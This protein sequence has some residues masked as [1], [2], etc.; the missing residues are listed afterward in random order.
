MARPK[1]TEFLTRE[2]IED[3][4]LRMSDTDAAKELGVGMVTFYNRRI[5]FGIPSF[6]QRTGLRK[7]KNGETY[8]FLEYNENYFQSIDTPAK[9][10][11]L[12]LLAADGNISPR[13]TA[14][15]IAL[16]E[17]DQS[18]L[19][20]FRRELGENAP[21][22]KDKIPYI[23]GKAGRTQKVL[24]LSRVKMVNDLI[25]L[26]ITPNKSHTLEMKINLKDEL[27][28]HFLRGVWDGDG[29]VTERRFKV[30]TGS[31][32][33]AKQLQKWMLD[34]SGVELPIKIDSIRIVSGEKHAPLYAIP[35]YLQ[36]ARVIQSIYGVDGP[37]MSRKRSN[38]LKYW[39]PRR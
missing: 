11:F 3:Y 39:D 31:L 32:N 18:I 20:E 7:R 21:R 24:C 8:S 28:G 34:V 26:G 27:K 12:G 15:R 22:L 19:E 36:D 25:A 9:A 17:E 2:L 35:G 30:S 16:K 6:F 4:S 23:K 38:Y 5:A 10:Y 13:L 14:V 33:F 1:S 37:V 29:S